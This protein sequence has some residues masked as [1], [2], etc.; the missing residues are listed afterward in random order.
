M[1]EDE[2]IVGV[3]AEEAEDRVRIPEQSKEE[4]C[5]GHFLRI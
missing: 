5:R 2:E 3:K 4:V 1:K